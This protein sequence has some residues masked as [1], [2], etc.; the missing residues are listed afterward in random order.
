MSDKLRKFLD[1][2]IEL[3][4]KAFEELA[5]AVRENTKQKV[6]LQENSKQLPPRRTFEIVKKIGKTY[7]P[8]SYKRNVLY[9]CRNNC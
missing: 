4:K 6:D 8:I 9:R 5:S 3:I 7:N 2:L 1:K